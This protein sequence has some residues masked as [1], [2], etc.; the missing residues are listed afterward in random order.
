MIR[1][2]RINLNYFTG[3]TELKYSSPAFINI[4]YIIYYGV[5]NEE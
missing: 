5:L 2:N 1:D 4:F 3:K